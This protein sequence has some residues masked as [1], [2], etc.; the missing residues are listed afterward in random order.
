MLCVRR[1]QNNV[2]IHHVQLDKILTLDSLEQPRHT[3][4]ESCSHVKPP[5][6]FEI[7]LKCETVLEDWLT[8]I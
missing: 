4:K 8:S 6:P 5:S 7:E 1:L 2:R 3:Y